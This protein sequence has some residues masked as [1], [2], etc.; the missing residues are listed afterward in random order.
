M[1]KPRFFIT[2]VF[3]SRKY[4]GNPLA[5]FIDGES[6]SDQEMQQ[7]AREINFTETTFITSRQPKDSPRRM[8]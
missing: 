1:H 8:A 6:L 2:D 7:V 4:G 3:T 5:T